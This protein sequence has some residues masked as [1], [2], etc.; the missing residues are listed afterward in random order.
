[1]VSVLVLVGVGVGVGVVIGIPQCGYCDCSANW[2]RDTIHYLQQSTDHRVSWCL[3]WQLVVHIS[4]FVCSRILCRCVDEECLV[5]SVFCFILF[6]LYFFLVV[7]VQVQHS[8]LQNRNVNERKIKVRTK[9][10]GGKSKKES[11][12]VGKP[13]SK[14]IANA[15]SLS[16]S[17]SLSYTLIQSRYLAH[18]VPRGSLNALYWI[19]V[20]VWHY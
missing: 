18:S 14:E 9:A 13:N 2:A 4:P 16:L 11:R 6:Y 8:N 1:M 3:R 7:Q 17:L 19:A 12:K 5:W 20:W 15:C 10:R